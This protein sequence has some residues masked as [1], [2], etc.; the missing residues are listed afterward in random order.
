MPWR[1]TISIW[2]WIRFSTSLLRWKP[3]EIGHPPPKLQCDLPGLRPGE[4]S[5]RPVFRK[6]AVPDLNMEP[7]W[8]L[9]FCTTP[10]SAKTKRILQ[11]EQPAVPRPHQQTHA[12][13]PH[14][15]LGGTNPAESCLTGLHFPSLH[16]PFPKP[17]FEPKHFSPFVVVKISSLPSAKAKGHRF[18]PKDTASQCTEQRFHVGR[19]VSLPSEWSYGDDAST[20]LPREPS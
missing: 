13:Q 15:G 1:C 8:D 14:G 4:T 6:G 9:E 5:N 11:K 2:F 20:I 7:F 10:S 12:R 16:M 3:K 17:P 19:P 18:V